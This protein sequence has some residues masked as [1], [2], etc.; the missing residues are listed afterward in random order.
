MNFRDVELLSAYLDGQ[1]SP[2]DSIRL[3]SRLNSDL[4][5]KT[6]LD[7]L[8]SARGLLRQLPQRSIPR[9]FTLTPK[10]SGLKAP[11]PRVYP[12]LR[13]ATV[14]AA[15]VFIL[16]FTVNG[17][18]PLA[19]SHLTAAPA[20]AYG[21]GGGGGG[22][23]DNCGPSESSPS[24]TEVPLQAFSAIAPTEALPAAQDNTRNLSTPTLELA[25]KTAPAQTDN[26]QP[27]K[28]TNETPIPFLWQVSIGLF[29]IICGTAAWFVRL[30]NEREFHK[31]WNK[32]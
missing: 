9:N 14:L 18:A 21:L 2:S 22:G 13:L 7:D 25:P 26:N 16:T 23:C 17:F 15:L 27:A 20:P 31:Q 10:M 30:R 19:A 4:Q 12:S 5:L 11:V 3:E 29:A 1:L 32:K 6:I 8:R 28:S 24:T